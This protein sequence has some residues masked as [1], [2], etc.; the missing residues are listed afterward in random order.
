MRAILTYENLG[1]KRLCGQTIGADGTGEFCI[2]YTGDEI[3]I[4]SA[5]KELLFSLEK[6]RQLGKYIIVWDEET[7]FGSP[8]QEIKL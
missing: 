5:I 1:S 4:H 8:I 7:Y 3:K 2:I 6:T